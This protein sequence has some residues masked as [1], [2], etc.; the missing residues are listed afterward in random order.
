[1]TIYRYGQLGSDGQ[2]IVAVLVIDDQ[3]PIIASGNGG[4]FIPFAVADV[5]GNGVDFATT[6]YANDATL[7]SWPWPCVG[8]GGQPGL[9]DAGWTASPNPIQ[10]QPPGTPAQTSLAVTDCLG[11]TQ[12]VPQGACG[13][14]PAAWTFTPPADYIADNP[15]A[16]TSTGAVAQ[17]ANPVPDPAQPDPAKT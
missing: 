5:E 17:V 11:N 4:V 10:A 12:T 7:S 15:D 8:I 16:P 3:H 6:D 13:T 9:A 14:V 2:T 1:M